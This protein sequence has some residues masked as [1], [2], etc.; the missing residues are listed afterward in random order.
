[1]GLE[2]RWINKEMYLNE[3]TKA[4]KVGDKKE[5]R[6]ILKDCPEIVNDINYNEETFLVTALRFNQPQIANYLIKAGADTTYKNEYNR[7]ML[8]IAAESGCSVMIPKLIKAGVAIDNW[9]EYG[10][11]V[12][13]FAARGGDPET[14]QALAKAGADIN[15]RNFEEW[16][17]IMSAVLFGKTEAVKIL[18]KLGADMSVKDKL[19]S[20]R[21]LLMLASEYGHMEIAKLL[22]DH[23]ANINETNAKG[24]TAYDIA[25]ECKHLELAAYL[26]LEEQRSH[27]FCDVSCQDLRF[28]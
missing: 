10:N 25:L 9:D 23:G 28:V 3:L 27:E 11:C 12:M 24:E 7:D 13:Y 6:K 19:F 2:T 20:G 15:H 16:T 4:I 17:P 8:M 18:L 5:V 22:V 26:K 1:M 21:T 14:I